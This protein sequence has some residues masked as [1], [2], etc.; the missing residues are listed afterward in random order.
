MTAP[1]EGVDDPFLVSGNG[2][3][4]YSVPTQPVV[5]W[6]A[7]STMIMVDTDEEIVAVG[8]HVVL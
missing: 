2:T 7:V 6:L 3:H 4:G 1:G 8:G 5:C